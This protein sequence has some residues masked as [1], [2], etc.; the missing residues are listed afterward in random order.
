[1]KDGGLARGAVSARVEVE[2]EGFRKY[3]FLW[4]VDPVPSRLP[5]EQRATCSGQGHTCCLICEYSHC[6]FA[7][8]VPR[9]AGALI[10][11]AERATTIHAKQRAVAGRGCCRKCSPGKAWGL[12]C[13]WG[14]EKEERE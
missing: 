14:S 12:E 3:V 4:G 7:L 5:L 9:S 11:Q 13:E 6:Q 8:T 10:P 1:M 2:R